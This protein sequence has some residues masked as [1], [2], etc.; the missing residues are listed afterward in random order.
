LL[1]TTSALLAAGI[2]AGCS[3]PAPPPAGA[4]TAVYNKVTGQ[5]EQLISD[6]NGDGKPDT[7]AFMS[8]TR[9]MKEF[10]LTGIPVQRIEN[11]SATCSAALRAAYLAVSPGHYDVAMVLGFDKM[12]T[13]IQSGTAGTAPENMEDAILP[14]GFFAM[15]ATRRMHERGTKPE[16]LAR[17]AA[18]N[19][20]NGAHNPM[21]QRQAKEHITPERVAH[22]RRTLPAQKRHQLTDD[23]RLA[24]SWMHSILRELAGG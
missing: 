9:I 20:N 2:L 6:R 18:K 8:G 4:P 23:I 5:L 10:G 16:H 15:W 21:A 22:L 7:W 17:I 12:T 1:R 13:M 24:P 3:A 11:A 14:A 19:F